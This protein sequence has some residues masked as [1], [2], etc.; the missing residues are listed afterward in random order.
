MTRPILIENYTDQASQA[1]TFRNG[2][3]AS[4]PHTIE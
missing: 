2:H 4:E 1:I 3:R